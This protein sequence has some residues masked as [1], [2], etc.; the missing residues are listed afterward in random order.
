VTKRPATPE[1]ESWRYKLYDLVDFTDLT[2]DGESNFDW[3]DIMMLITI[4]VS[5]IPLLFLTETPLLL[6]F[7]RITVIIFIID[8]FLR[9][10]T[11]DIRTGSRGP[12]AF[13]RYPFSFM[14]IMDLLSIIPS[15]TA[16]SETFKLLKTF[17][18]LK[19]LRLIRTLKLFKVVRIARYSRQLDIIMNVLSSSKEALCAVCTLAAGYIFISALIVFNVEPET[20]HTFFD[21]I[22]WATV[23]LTT[24]GYGD[25]YPVTVIGK[26]IAMLSSLFG[27]AVVALPA[28]II[29]AG[30]M[31][32]L[33]KKHKD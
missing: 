27:I 11:A 10:M 32:E 25:I 22:Y 4:I 30:Y 16:L 15:L 28:G 29:T 23:S 14:A 18:M 17:R 7:D 19:S 6:W 26:T 24:V 9:W 20:F 13:L 2:G 21:A 33:N 5:V 3:Y 8:Y 12:L 1:T 31:T